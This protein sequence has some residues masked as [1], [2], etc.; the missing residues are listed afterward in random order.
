MAHVDP[1]LA[2]SAV[3]VSVPVAAT[4]EP[5]VTVRGLSKTFGG[6]H[7]LKGVDL[8]FFPGEIHALCGENGAGK[9]TL[10]KILAGLLPPDHGQ[11]TITRGNCSCSSDAV[12][13]TDVAAVFQESVSC[14]DLTIA[15]NVFV[16]REL[17]WCQGL[18]LD[19]SAM[20][21]QAAE[22]VS[23]LGE[24]V[25]PNVV[26][27]DCS[28]AQRQIVGIARALSKR[29]RLLILDE[30]TASLSSRETEIL[31]RRMRRLK[32]SGTSIIYVSHRMEEVLALSDRVSVLRDG[33]LI[34]TR[35]TMG[36]SESQLI[37]LM[38][39]RRIAP[40]RRMQ[41][42][43]STS[44][45]RTALS[46]RGLTSE[47]V[48]ADVSFDV[49][50]GEIVGLAGLVGAGRSE[51]ASAIFGITHYD[52][53]SITVDGTLLRP[54]SVRES[55]Q[56]RIA[57]V[58]EDRQKQGL[59]LPMSIAHNLT[60]AILHTLARFGL[61]TRSVESNCILEKQRELDIRMNN[62]RLAVS[63]LSG[64]NQQKV[65]LGKWLSAN[66]SVLILD[67]PTR[68]VDVG[69]KDEIHRQI[70]E[71][72]DRGV[73]TLLI[74]SDLPELLQLSDRVLVMRE[75]SISGELLRDEA[76]EQA[77]L[78]LALPV[79]S[80]ASQVSVKSSL[81]S[82]LSKRGSN[83][84]RDFSQK[85]Q[86]WL[87]GLILLLLVVLASTTTGFLAPGNLLDIAQDA[88]PVAIIA[89]MMTLVIATGEI[90][91]S[92]GSIVGI[93]AAVLGFMCYGDAPLFPVVVGVSA[94]TLAGLA[95]GALNGLLIAYGRI[96]SIVVTLGMLTFLRGTTKLVMGGSSIYGRPE[97]LRKFATGAV[98]GIPTSLLLAGGVAIFAYAITRWTPFG[99]RIFAIG[100]NQQAAPYLSIS[101]RPVKF[102]T[103]TLLGLAAGL[104][105]VILAPRNSLI[106]PNIGE[107]L[108]LLVITCVVVGGT[109]IRGGSGS[110]SGT[111][112][113]VVLLAM[114]P[115]MLTFVGAPAEWRL[116]IEG[117]IILSAVLVDG[118]H[119][120]H[121][122]FEKG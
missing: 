26:L 101:P 93:A 91:V 102:W 113:A 97:S 21:R 29:C 86:F 36:L 6:V 77:V 80:A 108:E 17:I 4:T 122:G 118:H 88:A 64:G 22:L 13:E 121:R 32:S 57:L 10:I 119:R 120:L 69:A 7:A 33:M 114:I 38:V 63:A 84:S 79:T 109:S 47:Q 41:P 76:T 73:A 94:A 56:H 28:L 81:A 115:T 95:L 82:S 112:L 83:W 46:I 111:L 99:L 24:S 59:I 100:S 39:G 61:L 35:E 44:A 45:S 30:P 43:H 49:R 65:V 9:S 78:Q 74:S 98:V 50:S 53:G 70:C 67:E 37:D 60:L 75:G 15:E 58:P 3:G 71:L 8:D 51:L 2:F 40:F 87:A 27:T 42:L 107:G 25:S 85:R 1:N 117:A 5:V 52:S 66:P 105:A 106:Q 18:L 62:P 19:R 104:A 34:A 16:G 92:V 55:I 68:G 72:T 20:R 12:R 48:F 54:G 103:F 96:P 31:F 89:C 110:I 116:A 11:I 90:D 14:D 23:Q